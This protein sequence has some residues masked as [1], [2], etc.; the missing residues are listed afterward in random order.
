MLDGEVYGVTD[1]D[2]VANMVATE[3]EDICF[4]KERM[5]P[6]MK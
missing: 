6:K 4:Q 5:A 2:D 1:T 3:V